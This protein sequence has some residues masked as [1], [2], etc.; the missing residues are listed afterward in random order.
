[1]NHDADKT[2]RILEEIRKSVEA[3]S[4]K[5]AARPLRHANAGGGMRQAS[6]VVE[7][8]RAAIGEW[9]ASGIL[10]ELAGDG[11][12]YCGGDRE[13]CGECHGG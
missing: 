13:R 7:S 2:P 6:G 5:A 9:H 4:Y 12:K 8:L 3:G 10:R 11:C 1:M